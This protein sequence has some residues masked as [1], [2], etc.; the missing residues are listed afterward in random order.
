MDARVQKSAKSWSVYNEKKR[1]EGVID[2]RNGQIH[3]YVSN[4]DKV[5]EKR[6]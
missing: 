3:I 1:G 2:A 5:E 6:I 4:T